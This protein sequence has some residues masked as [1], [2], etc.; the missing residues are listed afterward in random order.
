VLRCAT[1]SQ[2]RPARSSIDQLIDR[3]GAL[4]A[5][6]H[7]EQAATIP[8]SEPYLTSSS[9][10]K[11]AMKRGVFR[12]TR[13]ATRRSDRLATE[14]ASTALELAERLQ[15]I[16]G[17]LERMRGD[18]DRL[19]RIAHDRSALERSSVEAG[20][21]LVDDAYYWAF[22]GRMRGDPASVSE[23]LRQYERLAVPLRER[24]AAG[25]GDD[26]PLWLD[27][28]C[29]RGEF[30]ELVLEWGWRVEGVDSSPVAVDSCRAKGIDTTLADVGL[31]L[32]TR[33]GEPPA[34]I[35]AIQLI[36]HVPRSE[37]L[38]LLGRAHALLRPGGA[39]LMET[40]NGLNPEAVAASFIAD[41]T[42]TWPGH[43][44]TLRLM[45]E[46]T[47]FTDVEVVFLNPDPKGNAQDFAIWASKADDAPAR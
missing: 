44:E 34:A 20:P 18:I 42:H 19:D 40:I 25:E 45:A 43:P 9:A 36:E 7:E 16:D 14:L 30:C 31:Y 35:S 5:Q 23:R 32:E 33:R 17:D 38:A 46:H 39:L 28:G 8:T 21:A 4:V 12:V 24:L 22:E 27:L 13:P 6:L 3:L 47:G 11:G 26:L 37:W 10:V 29:G 1:V 41:V 15:A 2:D